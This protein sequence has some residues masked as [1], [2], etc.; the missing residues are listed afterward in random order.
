MDAAPVIARGHNLAIFVPPVPA[1]AAPH[2][3][4][5][6]EHRLTLIITADADRAVALAGAQTR[7]FA[8]SGLARAARRLAAGAPE[9]LAVAAADALQ[10][11]QR[12]QLKCA[13]F[14][15]VVL[16]WPEQ[17]DD[18]GERRLARSWRKR[19]ATRSA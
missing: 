19:P 7:M 11:L 13:E 5:I 18:E 12:S 2:L 16:A 10:L 3:Q 4:A 14:Q 17:L 15:T 8:V 9:L 1:A 6:P